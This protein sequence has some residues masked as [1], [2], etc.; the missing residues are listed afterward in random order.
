MGG[1]VV[2]VLQQKQN[3]QGVQQWGSETV[4]VEQ[5]LPSEN[6]ERQSTSPVWLACLTLT[7]HV[8]SRLQPNLHLLYKSKEQCW[9][10]TFN[11]RM[12]NNILTALTWFVVSYNHN[13][14]PNIWPCFGFQVFLAV[15]RPNAPKSL[16]L[17]TALHKQIVVTSR[18]HP[19][20][21]SHIF[22]LHNSCF[23]YL[24]VLYTEL[25]FVR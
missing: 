1:S 5:E 17:F 23:H 16:M 6:L 4:L 13:F 25:H 18:C 19:L 10:F 2:P 24:S 15:H 20:N 11:H 12:A 9:E 7:S 21:W 14:Y 8:S 3:E 22:Y